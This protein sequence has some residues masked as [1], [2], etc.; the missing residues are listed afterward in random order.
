MAAVVAILEAMAAAAGAILRATAVAADIPLVTAQ[1][2]G[3]PMLVRFGELQPASIHTTPLA[4]PHTRLATAVLVAVP[5]AVVIPTF[6]LAALAAVTQVPATAVRADTVR[7]VP[8]AQFIMAALAVV[9]P[10]DT[11][12]Q[13]MAVPAVVTTVE[14]TTVHRSKVME[15]LDRATIVA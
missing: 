9:R 3:W 6:L 1:A 4:G 8:T 7:K 2:A 11:L 14:A 5:A 15:V 10:A 13:A 12:M